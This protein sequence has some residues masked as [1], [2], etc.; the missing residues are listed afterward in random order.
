MNFWLMQPQSVQ[1]LPYLFPIPT[2]GLLVL[3]QR[4]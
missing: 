4:G 1:T 2:N 3:P